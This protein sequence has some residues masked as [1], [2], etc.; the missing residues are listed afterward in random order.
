M[1]MTKITITTIE[2]VLGWKIRD[3]FPQYEHLNVQY[4]SSDGRYTLSYTDY[5]NILDDSG[6]GWNLHVDSS[7]HETLANCSVEYIEQVNQIIEL[8][9]KY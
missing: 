3:T 2:E 4:K 1:E 8:Y 5:V 6:F 7:D 9:R